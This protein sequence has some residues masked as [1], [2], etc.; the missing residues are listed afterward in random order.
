MSDLNAYGS[1]EGEDVPI[2]EEV[3]ECVAALNVLGMQTTASCGGHPE[4]DGLG[5]PVVQGILEKY[6]DENHS[7]REKV[8]ALI[9]EFN[10][11]RTTPFTMRLHPEVIDGFRIESIV[12]EEGERMM[13][14]NESGYDR[15]KMK[16][17]I[18]GAQAEFHAFAD[19][20]K[21]KIFGGV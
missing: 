2:D 21:Q 16:E 19:F 7:P 11:G 3:K 12:S 5:F 6:P 10:S 13:A 9:D 15:Q 4:K 8:Q 1:R 14:K 20:L 18:L 17:L